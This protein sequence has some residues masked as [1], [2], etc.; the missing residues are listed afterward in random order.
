M[1]KK[2]FDCSRDECTRSLE[3]A[4]IKFNESYKEMQGLESSKRD[5]LNKEK[6]KYKDK[7]DA[8]LAGLRKNCEEKVK[9]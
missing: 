2:E 7:L 1:L 6:T 3:I 9:V 4:K 8:K 5:Y